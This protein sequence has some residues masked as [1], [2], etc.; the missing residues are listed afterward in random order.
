VKRA[1]VTAVVTIL[2]ALAAA[3]GVF[4]FMGSVRDGAETVETV[5][6]V[7]STQDLPAAQELDPLIESG[8]FQTKV[9]PRD[10]LVSG[11]ITDVYQLQGQRLAYPV[12]VGEQIPAARLAG[13]LQAGGGVLGIPEGYQAAA[14]TLESQRLVAG[15]IQPGDHIE[16]FGTFSNRTSGK[17]TTRVVI[18]DALVLAVPVPDEGSTSGVTRDATITLAVTP[19]DASLLIFS[20]EQGR[21]WLTLLPPNQPGVEVPAANQAALQR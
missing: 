9:V 4:L 3:G 6:V 17:P 2:F 18:P 21:V 10:D 15:A 11:V 1:S 8:V 12:L 16:V 20:Q 19:E 14:I 13:P 7:V 5:S